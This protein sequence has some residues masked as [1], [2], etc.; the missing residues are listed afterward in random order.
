MS[1]EQASYR[2]AELFGDPCLIATSESFKR[3]VQGFP[4]LNVLD[5]INNMPGVDG[6]E[7][8]FRGTLTV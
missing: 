6:A 7:L 1:G 2:V 8:R 4:A 5:L 3:V